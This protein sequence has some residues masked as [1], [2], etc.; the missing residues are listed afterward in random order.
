M[1]ASVV[2]SNEV[3]ATPARATSTASKCGNITMVNAAGGVIES[4][5]ALAFGIAA[6]EG[7]AHT[8]INQ[9]SISTKGE[10]SH[11][12]L[13]VG[14]TGSTVVNVGSIT[15]SG[16]SSETLNRAYGVFVAEGS[17]NN[18]ILNAAGGTIT[19][20]GLG[21]SGMAV[22]NSTGNLLV[23]EGTLNVSGAGAQGIYVVSGAG[24]TLD[25][26]GQ[27]NIT[28]ARG[29][30]LRSDDGSTT[31]LN[32]GAIQVGGSD[33][34]GVYM[35]GNGNTLTNSGTI[36]AT[37][38]NADGV[39]SNTVAGSFVTII[40]NTGSIISDKRFAVRGVNGQ[41]TLINSGTI[42]SG[43]GTAIDL[44]A[45]NDTLILRAG[46]QI[47]GLADGGTGTDTTLLEGNGV[48]TNDFQNFETLRMSGTDWR[49]SGN[50]SFGATQVQ[51]GMLR[52]DGTLSSPVSVQAGSTLQV[53]T[54]GA[55]GTVNGDIANGG[56]LV[57]NRSDVLAYNGQVSGSG[58]VVQQG[59]GTLTLGGANSYAGGTG[60]NGGTLAVA[61]DNA[62][63]ASAGPLSFNGGT[64]RFNAGFDL[65]ASRAITLQA[66]GGTM[67]TQGFSSKLVQSIGGSGG[68]TK[69][70]SGTLLL[71]GANAY[72]GGTTIAGGTLQL[73]DGGTAGS[74][75]GNVLNNGSLA[76]NRSDTA[77]FA[78]T[79]SGSGSLSQL[80]RAPRC[81][82]RP[83]ATAAAPS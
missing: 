41:E 58:A 79:I 19:A 7:A 20:S 6:I 2:N 18:R 23:N 64:L 63:G 72:T 50:G 59:P 81:C 17:N 73:G 47:T 70:G 34:F 51:S 3:S 44:R 31:F 14:T 53:G 83:T 60:I 55:S 30:G 26:R 36:R 27:L 52:V 66:G 57:F 39:V 9:G 78:G 45:G 12:I 16:G 65:A 56:T 75:Q 38:T 5:Q 48:A 42:Q 80:A 35:Q 13:L 24:N 25:N 1:M 71:T 15:T 21:S 32:S 76:F 33:A 11:G 4:T 8:I 40:E 82:R 22:L 46:S 54:G 61:A 37:G 43:A 69:A 67:D 68:L 74:L 62:L 77:A 49:F 10:A 29:N 28:G